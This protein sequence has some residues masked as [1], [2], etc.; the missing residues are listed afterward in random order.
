MERMEDEEIIQQIRRRG[1]EEAQLTEMLIKKY[2]PLVNREI[3]FLFLAGAD[4]DDLAQE[5]MIGLYRAICSFQPEEGNRFITFAVTCVR[6]QLRDAV[7]AAGRQK[8]LPLNNF[9]SLSGT[10]DAETELTLSE[11]I[12][13]PETENPEAIYLRKEE[14]KDLLNEMRRILSPLELEVAKLYLEGLSRT[15]IAKRMGKDEKAVS[16]AL[17]RIR[18]KLSGFMEKRNTE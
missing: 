3:R 17:S 15:D 14:Q 8:N 4:A 10:E 16:N 12:G 9:V 6:N 5:G 1:E 18:K 2:I 13:G 11:V 7:K